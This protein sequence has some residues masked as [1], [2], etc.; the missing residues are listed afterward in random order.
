MQIAYISFLLCKY[1]NNWYTDNFTKQ[2]ILHFNTQ[3]SRLTLNMTVSH[4]YITQIFEEQF[5]Y[6]FAS[7]S[8]VSS[9]KKI[10]I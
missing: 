4:V 10:L 7:V 1:K 2:V 5:L 3:N 9:L 8:S 6:N